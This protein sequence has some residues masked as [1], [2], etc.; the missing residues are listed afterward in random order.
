MNG[1]PSYDG[2]TI[3]VKIASQ[4]ASRSSEF[5]SQCDTV[6]CFHAREHNFL[7]APD[8]SDGPTLRAQLCGG[9]FQRQPATRNEP[10]GCAHTLP[11]I[12]KVLSVRRCE[13]KKVTIFM[14][15]YLS[16]GARCADFQYGLSKLW[17]LALRF[18]PE[19]R[20]CPAMN[21]AAC[22]GDPCRCQSVCNALG[23]ARHQTAAIHPN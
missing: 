7:T 21:N 9:V 15:N 18:I 1:V 6:H 3:A 23:T 17:S 13:R 22:A 10:V 14:L 11:L 16:K 2:G 5:A 20:E 19:T 4:D 8:I 12:T